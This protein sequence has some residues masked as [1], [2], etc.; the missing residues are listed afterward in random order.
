MY[1]R[2]GEKNHTRLSFYSIFIRL[3]ILIKS[4]IQISDNSINDEKLYIIF[5]VDRIQYVVVRF[6]KK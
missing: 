3:F 5:K 4:L 2:R 6:H 1:H